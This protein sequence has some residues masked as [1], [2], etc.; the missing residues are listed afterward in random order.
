MSPCV[1][2]DR[3]TVVVVGWGG[4]NCWDK[5]DKLDLLKRKEMPEEQ[6][7]RLGLL[8]VRPPPR[9]L[10]NFAACATK[11]SVKSSQKELQSVGL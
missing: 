4:G 2:N 1:K 3:E 11:Y 9:L 7:I 5:L 8:V 6:G 10:F